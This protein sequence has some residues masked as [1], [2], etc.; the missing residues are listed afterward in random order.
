MIRHEI[1]KLVK[2]KA[3]WIVVALTFIFPIAMSFLMV[4]VVGGDGKVQGM[5]VDLN[6]STAL[7]DACANAQIWSILAMVVI[8]SLVVGD[9]NNGI[10]RNMVM[11]G[12]PRWK[13]WFVKL[14][15]SVILTVVAFG[16]FVLVESIIM[17]A[18]YGR[19]SVAVGRY[20]GTL[21]VAALL[22]IA[23]SSVI[24]FLADLTRNTGATLGITILLF[25]AFSIFTMC[26]HMIPAS[27]EALRKTFEIIGELFVGNVLSSAASFTWTAAKM[28][29]YVATSVATFAVCTG[30]G[31]WLFCRRDL[32]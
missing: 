18:W 20:F 2:S 16:I 7:L 27:N 30:L 21:C 31:F 3:F 29:Q 22:S 10:V 28:W 25:I 17:G 26:V 12:M 14:G 32:K 6:A 9:Y 13:V 15:L 24:L 23:L 4:S 5:P 11:S 19:G 1:Y 8:S